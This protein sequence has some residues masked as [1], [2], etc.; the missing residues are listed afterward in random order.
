VNRTHKEIKECLEGKI[1]LETELV[2][3]VKFEASVPSVVL[4]SGKED[5]KKDK[6]NREHMIS[7]KPI[8]VTRNMAQILRSARLKT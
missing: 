6:E 8:M 3:T 7:N 4:V 1:H 5:R 2:E